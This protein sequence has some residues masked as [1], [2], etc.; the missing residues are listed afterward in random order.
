METIIRILSARFN[1][2]W[3]NTPIS[4]GLLYLILTSF[5]L[6][7]FL[8]G[9]L[10]TFALWML[11]ATLMAMRDRHELGRLPRWA[12]YI[13]TYVILPVGALV[14]ALYNWTFASVLF[15][16][17]P[18]E[19]MLTSR[20]KRYLRD[21]ESTEW[22]FYVAMWICKYLVEPHDFNHCGMEKFR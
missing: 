13:G 15:L 20:L 12:F 7:L 1:N 18:Q 4:V 9:L 16:D 21:S 6:N 22:R 11:F 3:I 5:S 8:Y 19:L 14:D 17:Y 2:G 10:A